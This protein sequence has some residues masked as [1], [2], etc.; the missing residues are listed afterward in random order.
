[1]D[2]IQLKLDYLSN[3]LFTTLQ[4]TL[5]SYLKIKFSPQPTKLFVLKNAEIGLE[6][7]PDPGFAKSVLGNQRLA[8]LISL[9]T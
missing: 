1:M 2:I 9:P 8:L 4:F 7:L 5:E 3:S 6:S